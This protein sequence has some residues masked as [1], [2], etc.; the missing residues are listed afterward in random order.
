MNIDEVNRLYR[1]RRTVL[2]MLWDRGYIVTDA[3][4]DMPFEEFRN[5]HSRDGTVARDGLLL[6]KRKKDDYADVVMVAFPPEAKVA[7]AYVR[8][9]MNR[10]EGE[11]A[12]RGILVCQTGITPMAKTAI[13]TVAEY[14]IED[15]TE[16]ELMINITRHSLVPAHVVL[17]A[18]DKHELLTRYKLKETQLPRMLLRDPVARYY[19]LQRGQV[20]RISRA[21]ETAGR[22]I[23]YRLVI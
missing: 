23:T 19:G 6:L 5:N 17:S 12:K 9:F 22:Y 2:E 15:F 14:I 21:S 7:T 1:V 20:V 3:E 4:R 13:Q 11:G 18:D 10:L 16:Q 8:E